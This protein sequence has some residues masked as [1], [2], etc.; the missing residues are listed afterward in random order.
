MD[1]V[2]C[3]VAGGGVIGIAIARE[4]ARRGI[5]TLIVEEFGSV[6]TGTSSRNSGV[7][8]AG[9]YYP[10]HSLKARFCVEGNAALYR[11]AR[12]YGV[13][14]K[15]CGKLIVATDNKQV[16]IL[17][18]IAGRAAACGVK[19]LQFLSRSE[20]QLLEPDLMCTAAIMSPSTGIIDCHALMLAL[21][22]DAQVHGAMIAFNTKV[23]SVVANSDG[24]VLGTVETQSGRQY[25]FQ[26]AMFINACGLNAPAL[27]MSIAALPKKNVPQ[28][29]YAKGNY[30]S[31]PGTAPF[32]HLVY[33]VPEIGGLGIHLTLD[34]AGSMRF[35]PDV[36][37]INAIDYAVDP[38]RAGVFYEAIRK[39]WPL[40]PDGCLEPAYCGVRP[41]LSIAGSAVTDFMIE[42]PAL[43]SVKGLVNVFGI[44]SP[45]LTSCL[46]IAQYVSALV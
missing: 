9:L 23:E 3:V 38:A 32:R 12:D 24:F 22:G 33:P 29:R 8:H 36:E 17:T 27:A 14:H 18:Q 2:G 19:N 45:G 16:Q 39:Y 30:F 37:W 10:E 13:P 35:G 11:F 41:K 20:A 26:S 6:G 44:E 43:H 46:P 21:L 25:E 40:L 15:Q 42:G 34:L 7:I 31:V 4:L 1:Q 28:S 5:E